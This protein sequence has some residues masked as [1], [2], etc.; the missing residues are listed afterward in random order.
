MVRKKLHLITITLLLFCS[1][2]LFAQ[3]KVADIPNPKDISLSNWVSN[4]DNILSSDA[5]Q[6]V[7]AKLNALSDSTT[8]QIV[9]VVIQG[10][11]NTDVRELSMNLFDSW[12]PGL[13]QKNNGIIVL[14]CT[15]AK[16]AFIRTGYGVESVITDAFSTRVINDYMA[17]Y[18]KSGQWDEGVIAGVNA[19]SHALIKNY[20][21]SGNMIADAGG[22]SL[23]NWL[24]IYLVIGLILLILCVL[25]M[26][27]VVKGIDK[28]NRSKKINAL[29]RTYLNTS[30]LTF[31]FT[32]WLLPI[33]RFFYKRT[34]NS[35]RREV[36]KCDCG[37]KMRLLSEQEE[38]KY[39]NQRQQL[40][41]QLNSRDY[42]V[43]LCDK[44]G[45]INVYCYEKS[46]KYSR[47]PKCNA[48]AYS[49]TSEEI[50]HKTASK[51]I[52]RK[53]YKCK[54]CSYTKVEEQ[55][56]DNGN[57]NIGAAMM[58]GAIIG[59]GGFSSSSGSYGGSMGSGFGGGLS[60]GGGGGGSW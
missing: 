16:R 15:S 58:G 40:E 45:Q 42:D 19:L 18:F 1:L 32:W 26:N 9:V 3:D 12:R 5:V 54:S 6:R 4:P 47:C 48:K 34:Y 10:E 2:S 11:R 36:V 22:M 37:A 44:C 24:I 38:D 57:S 55:E 28:K 27:S 25:R 33:Y 50:I 23:T 43:W 14:V 30:V 52:L 49:K 53:T 29:K 7:N 59:S 13:K 51:D 21:S 35:I 56:V 39:L 17:P 31:L 60:G 46:S 41:E 8:C 20:D